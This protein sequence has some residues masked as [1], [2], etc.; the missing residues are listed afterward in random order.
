M[1]VFCAKSDLLKLLKTA[2]EA[3][4]INFERERSNDK[5]VIKRRDKMQWHV[6]CNWGRITYWGGGGTNGKDPKLYMID[7]DAD[8]I[9]IFSVCAP[10]PPPQLSGRILV[11]TPR[12]TSNI[13]T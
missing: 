6:L 11:A 13:F 5:I 9:Y 12:S 1:F 2:I 10:P 8:I 7:V 3:K 4:V